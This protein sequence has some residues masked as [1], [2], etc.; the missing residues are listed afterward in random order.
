MATINLGRIKPVF[1]GAYS[2]ATAYVVDD[3]VTSS[4][5]TFIC[6]LA[7]TGNA[8]SNATYWTKLAAK[9][10]DGA[11]GTNPQLSMTW[12]NATADADNGA[13]KIAWN[14]ATIASAT[15]LYVDDADDASANIQPYVDTWDAVT[16]TTAKGIVTIT[17][18]S[19]PATFATF[20][21][22][23]AV[24]DATGYSKIPVTHLVS[25]GTFS[26]GDGVGVHFQYS[27]TDGADGTDVGTT[28]TTEGDILYRDGSGLARLAK[29]AAEKVLS[30]NSGA[31]APEWTNV[32]LTVLPTISVAKGGTNIESFTAGDVLYATGSTTL[33]KLAKGTA[34]QVL[35][36]NAGATAP[37]WGSVDLTVLPTISVAKGGT[38][39]ASFTA[40]DIL[41]ATG[42]TTLAKLAKGSA[43]DTL[44]M[45]AGA[46][47]PEWVTVAAGGNTPSWSASLSSNQ[48]LGHTTWTKI[49]FDTEEH[50][51]DSAYDNATNY[52][53]TVPAGEDGKYFVTLDACLRAVSNGTGENRLTATSIG[54]YKNGSIYV[55][56]YY[57][58]AGPEEYH[59]MGHTHNISFVFDLVATDYL[60]G[61]AWFDHSTSKTD[62]RAEGTNKRCTFSGFKIG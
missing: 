25:N 19:T 41:Y 33:A 45:N 39:I 12:D 30:I 9:G 56:Q 22:S 27:G 43:A 7:S 52:R 34:E 26:D 62:S 50:D 38:N 61:Y 8:T 49:N 47:A 37:D 40:G 17:K 31:T 35:A 3:I 28:I 44:K 13:G 14:H 46:T 4:G 32:D 10:V 59:A 15:I 53:F 55:E 23:G 6:I 48:T 58:G 21:V 2:G 11:L 42:S 57:F 18:E 36:M 16:N 24:V 54:I 5:E 29:G 1:R 20:K 60:E 51:T